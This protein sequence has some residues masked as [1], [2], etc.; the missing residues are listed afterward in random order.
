M[1]FTRSVGWSLVLLAM[2]MSSTYGEILRLTWFSSIVFVNL[3]KVD[4]AL[5]PTDMC[6]NQKVLKG[7]IKLVLALSSSFI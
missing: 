4:P 7:V 3:E 6:L 1:F 5:R 2:T